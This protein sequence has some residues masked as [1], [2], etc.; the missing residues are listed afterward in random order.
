[1]RTKVH[2]DFHG[3]L[4]AG[5]QYLAERYGEKKLEEYLKFC[6][7]NIYRWL[8]DEIEKEGLSSL[9]RYWHRIFSL[10]EGQFEIK[11]QGDKEIKLVVKKCPALSHMEKAGYPVYKDFCLQCRIINR[12]L[13]EKTGLTSEVKSEQSKKR[14]IQTFKRK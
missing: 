12:V 5:F 6:G 13:A 14:C 4:S 11:R 8:I 3:A 9:E 2:K 7:E 1:M 10:E